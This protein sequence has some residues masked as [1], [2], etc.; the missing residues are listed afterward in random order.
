MLSPSL[1]SSLLL[2]LQVTVIH[3]QVEDLELKEK[4]DVIIS[5]CVG[6]ALL[7]GGMLRALATAK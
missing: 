1:L 4:V 2:H 5:D 6:P 7:G 3:A